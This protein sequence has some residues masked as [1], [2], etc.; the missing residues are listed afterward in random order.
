VCRSHSHFVMRSHFTHATHNAHACY[1]SRPVCA[2]THRCPSQ[3]TMQVSTR[4][5]VGH[6][7]HSI[8]SL[9]HGE[10]DGDTDCDG[11]G[12]NLHVRAQETRKHTTKQSR[13][14]TAR[15]G[16]SR[17]ADEQGEH[18]VITSHMNSAPLNTYTHAHGRMHALITSNTHQHHR[19]MVNS[20]LVV[21]HTATTN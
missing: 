19:A 6:T 1:P 7:A 8:D 14:R 20:C 21:A 3:C 16:T 2:H 13:S 11:N 12:D 17:K 10:E 15:V 4:A 5:H 9:S 18:R